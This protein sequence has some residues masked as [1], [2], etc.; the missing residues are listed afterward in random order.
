MKIKHR[1]IFFLLIV[2]LIGIICSGCFKGD[3]EVVDNSNEMSLQNDSKTMIEDDKEV[4]E[5]MK[6]HKDEV[7]KDIEKDNS[8]EA[9]DEGSL[10]EADEN[11]SSPWEFLFESS[12]E[13]KVEYAGFMNESIGVTVGY[14]GEISYTEDGGD[15][16]AISD[17]SSACRYGLDIYDESFIVSSGNSG[18]NLL[19]NDKGKSW[20]KLTDFPLKRSG[21]YNKF[22]SVIDTNNLYIASK[23]SL[24][25]SNDGGVTWE[26]L[27]LPDGCDSIVGMFFMTPENGYIFNSDGTLYITKDSCKSWTTQVLDLQGE[28]I[29]ISKMP[30]AAINFQSED[31]GMIIYS[32]TSYKVHCIKTED[33]GNTWETVDMPKVYYFAPYISRDGRYLTL[34]SSLKKLCLYTLDIE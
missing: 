16:W 22:M 14:A 2:M 5:S 33:G 10:E 21:E 15:S 27:A 29:I 19:S 30:S 11:N 9:E 6:D 23:I 4:L 13:T 34:S 32:T 31:E 7:D 1:V 17:N 20:T 26:E 3:E 8:E 28:K 24:G 25:V 12:V 18:V